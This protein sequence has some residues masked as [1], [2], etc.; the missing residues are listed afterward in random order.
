MRKTTIEYKG[1]QF[2]NKKGKIIFISEKMGKDMV[3]SQY[4]QIV[5]GS[6]PRLFVQCLQKGKN[7][8]LTQKMNS[9][10]QTYLLENSFI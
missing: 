10:Q 4:Y 8:L 7:H 3:V 1:V 2:S 5:S 6:K 9:G